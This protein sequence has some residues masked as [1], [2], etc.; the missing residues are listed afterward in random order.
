MVTKGIEMLNFEDVVTNDW[1]WEGLATGTFDPV[2]GSDIGLL[3]D[4]IQH[5]ELHQVRCP[6]HLVH[7]PVE[8]AIKHPDMTATLMTWLRARFDEVVAELPKSKEIRV[9]RIMRVEREWIDGLHDGSSTTGVYFGEE[10]MDLEGGYWI[11]T[12]LP[13]EVIIKGLVRASDVDWKGTI[14]ARMDHMTGD[15]E[16]EIRLVENASIVVSSIF[17]D[18]QVVKNAPQQMFSG[19]K[20]S[21]HDSVPAMNAGI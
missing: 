13:V 8:E 1:F 20:R 15:R 6:G 17:V 7:L 18:G 11:D 4:S 21:R 16:A 14:L 5:G 9:M 12:A 3:I 2:H 10:T 19:M